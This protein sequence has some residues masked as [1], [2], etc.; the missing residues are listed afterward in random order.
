[1]SI[2]FEQSKMNI[3]TTL[4]GALFQP[5][6]FLFAP[7]YSVNTVFYYAPNFPVDSVPITDSV[8]CSRRKRKKQLSKDSCFFL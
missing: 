3:N 8:K 2:F 6:L 5:I 4:F 1:M 7:F